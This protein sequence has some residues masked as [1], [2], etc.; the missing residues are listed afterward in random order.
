MH[1]ACK[2]LLGHPS[3]RAYYVCHTGVVCAQAGTLGTKYRVK[4]KSV[5]LTYFQNWVMR[6]H[7]G[8]KY[9]KNTLQNTLNRTGPRLFWR[10]REQYSLESTHAPRHYYECVITDGRSE[11][12]EIQNTTQLSRICFLLTPQPVASS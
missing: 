8:P 5:F 7:S 6:G 12:D 10:N 3:A 11:K 9:A 2:R 1:S 4:T